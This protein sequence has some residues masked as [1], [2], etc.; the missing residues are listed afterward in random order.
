MAFEAAGNEKLPAGCEHVN[1]GVIGAGIRNQGGRDFGGGCE[2][3][4]ANDK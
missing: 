1:V 3:G 4:A 2:V